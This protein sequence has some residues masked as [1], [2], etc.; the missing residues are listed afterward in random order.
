MKHCD[1]REETNYRRVS[2]DD[3]CGRETPNASISPTGDTG[4]TTVCRV[5]SPSS[6]P[7][8]TTEYLR[9]PMSQKD[10]GEDTRLKSILL[11]CSITNTQA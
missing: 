7:A 9:S 1:H 8:Q 2:R 4:A 3:Q 11:I 10:G 6:D 5:I